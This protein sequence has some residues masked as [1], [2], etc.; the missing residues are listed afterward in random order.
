MGFAD[1]GIGLGLQNKISEAFGCDDLQGIRNLHASGR[2]LLGWLSLVLSAVVLPL[3]WILPW[4]QWLKVEAPDLRA[5]VPLALTILAGGFA[6]G[7]PF[8]TGV[9][10]A[11][12]VQQG[13]LQGVWTAV[14]S[15][16]SLMM[17][18]LASWF[19]WP[20]AAFIMATASAPVLAN[21]GASKHVF[22]VL[23]DEFAQL[24]PH[25]QR[26]LFLPLLR[27]GLLF[28]LPQM[29][30]TI[31]MGAPGLMIAGVLGPG[32]VAPFTLCQRL[33][34]MLLLFQNM[35]FTALWPALTEARARGDYDW[36]LRSLRKSLRAGLI[37]GVVLG[38]FF[39]LGGHLLILVWTQSSEAVPTLGTR[40]G[41]ALWTMLLAWVS[42]AGYFL[43]ACGRLRGLAI[44]GA[45]TAILTLLIIPPFA[46]KF[47][48]SGVI[49]A[50]LIA[51]CTLAL[52]MALW[53]FYKQYREL[54]AQNASAKARM[55]Q[56]AC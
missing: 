35:P 44:G 40:L 46:L 37:S 14:G 12:G 19:H 25:V 13:W 30:A 24:H 31:M 52:P 43:N 3:C 5:Q 11:C 20:F 56:E 54:V 33:S 27:Q 48:V 9:R 51:W 21:L 18:A 34:G 39:A 38:T 1:L 26:G 10:L 32:S 22:R 41:F 6:C 55:P 15:L 23:G 53:D 7:L 50:M 36:M 45:L 4:G 17:V 8:N 28:L 49:A 29:S 47:G 16:G 42:A 2:R